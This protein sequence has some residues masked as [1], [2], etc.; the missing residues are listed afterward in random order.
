MAREPGAAL[1]VLARPQRAAGESRRYVRQRA[2]RVRPA[3]VAA[4]AVYRPPV[5]TRR[6]LAPPGAVRRDPHPAAL[7]S[8][9]PCALRVTPLRMAIRLRSP[10]SHGCWQLHQ[11]RGHAVRRISLPAGEVPPR[12][13]GL[14]QD[15]SRLSVARRPPAAQTTPRGD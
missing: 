13:A 2:V 11:L 9:H 1:L 15:R 4:G 10:G 5:G 6:P 8:A 3:D 7:S 12:T 14:A